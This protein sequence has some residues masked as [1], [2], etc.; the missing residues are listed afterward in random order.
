V[1][2]VFYA[3]HGIAQDQFYLVPVDVNLRNL[4]GTGISADELKERL[5]FPC[6]TLLLL[7]ACFAGSFDPA[8]KRALSEATDRA[9]RELVYDEGMVVMC[10]ANKEQV[11]GEEQSS[12]H[13]YFTRA[14]MQGLG[15]KAKPDE[16]GM[17]DIAALWSYVEPLVPKLAAADGAD[18]QTPTLSP[19][20]RMRSFALSKPRPGADAFEGER[21]E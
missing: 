10:G 17:I 20:S 11:A 21:T 19:P 9:V 12:Q 5:Q 18:E 7:D 6:D 14:L 13:G 8:R 3:G 4:A 15:G 16:D 1:A 2:V